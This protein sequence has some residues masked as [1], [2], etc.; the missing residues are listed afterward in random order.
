MARAISA[1]PLDVVEHSPPKVYRLDKRAKQ[2]MIG[3]RKALQ[4]EFQ[5]PR[6]WIERFGFKPATDLIVR[7][8]WVGDVVSK[9]RA[10]HLSRWAVKDALFGSAPT[11][12][13]IRQ[14]AD[15]GVVPLDS[16]VLPSVGPVVLLIRY[17]Q[18]GYQVLEDGMGTVGALY[19]DTDG[20]YQIQNGPRIDL[21][22][23][24]AEARL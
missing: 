17:A 21:T 20:R 6:L 15:G 22:L 16:G 24:I 1:N 4:S 12:I 11:E 23:L 2:E 10:F 18:G 13:L 7:A 14:S 8:S 9:D 19:I 3:R 5:R